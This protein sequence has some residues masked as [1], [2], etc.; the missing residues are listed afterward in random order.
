MFT[1]LQFEAIVRGLSREIAVYRGS[2]H[3]GFKARMTSRSD[4]AFGIDMVITQPETGKVLN[5]D[6]K[7]PPAFRHRLEDFLK[8]G[9]INEEQLLAADEADFMTTEHRRNDERVEVTMLCI[10]P[11]ILGEI[12]DF[13]FDDT[14]K[15]EMLLN[16]VFATI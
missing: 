5:I 9:R 10:R 3:R 14:Q 4:D 13:T 12:T 2:L 16:K 7:T 15:L 1:D 8:D 11:E 6:C